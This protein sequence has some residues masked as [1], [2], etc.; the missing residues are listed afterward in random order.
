[1]KS[2]D[3]LS[4]GG[5]F[6]IEPPAD[7]NMLIPGVGLKRRQLARITENSRSVSGS[8]SMPDEYSNSLQKKS[9]LN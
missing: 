1:M 6:T 7:A 5:Q 8:P 4:P 9:A 2:I 3:F